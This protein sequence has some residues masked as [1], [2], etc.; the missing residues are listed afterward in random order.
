MPR[1][2]AAKF[3]LQRDAILQQAAQLFAARGFAG[4]SMNELAAAAGVSKASL[5]HY[6]T[7]KYQLLVAIAEEHIDRLTALVAEADVTRAPEARL[8]GLIGR[9]VDEYADAHAH[10]Q[11]LVQD[12][13][14]LAADDQAR[15]RAKERTVVAAFAAAIAAVHPGL[16]SARLETPLTMLLFGMINWMFTWFRED[17]RL[18]YEDM[19]RL[20]TEFVVGG[21]AAV[22]REKS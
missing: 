7:D 21:L 12:I 14:Y 19:A 2:R 22:A 16:A 15:I 4:T 11:V 5:Y 1:G 13:K 8:R 9:F 17:G 20:V 6:F 18:G 3:P 10:H